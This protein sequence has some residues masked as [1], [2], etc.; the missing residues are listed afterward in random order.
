ML[1][2]R[3]LNAII[4]LGQFRIGLNTKDD[5]DTLTSD[6]SPDCVDVIFSKDNFL[7][8]R[9]GR[10]KLNSSATAA[11]D[12]GNGF[13]DFGVSPGVR[14]LV[15]K[16]G[17]TVYKMDDLDGTFDSL[18]TAQGDCNMHAAQSKTNLI[19]CR[20]DWGKVQYWDGITASAADLNAS[21]PKA[22]YP[23]NWE[24][25]LFLAYP[26]GNPRRFYYEDDTTTTT[27]TWA[28][29]WDIRTTTGGDEFTG[30]ALLRNRL[31]AFF[32]HS[33]HR[34][35]YLGG[36]PLF[37]VNELV[38][39]TGAVPRTIKNIQLPN[40]QEV[41]IFLNWQ[42]KICI[43]D[44]TYVQTIS[45][46]ISSSNGE[47]SFYLDN[48]NT[49]G[50][51]NC[52]ACVDLNRQWYILTAPIGGAT[53]NTHSLVLDYSIMAMFPFKNQTLNASL[54]AEDA[55]GKRYLIGGGYT[56]YAYKLLEGLTDD[57]GAITAFADGGS[58]TVT[59][60]LA[61]HGLNTGDKVVISGTTN[62]NGTFTLNSV[63]Q[64]TFN[65]T[66]TWVSNDGTGFCVAIIAEHYISSKLGGSRI[67]SLKK[68]RKITTYYAPVSNYSLTQYER[69]NFETSWTTRTTIPMYNY[70]DDFLGVDF[71]LGTSTLGSA[72]TKVINAVDLPAVNNLFQ[73]K[74]ASGGVAKRAWRLHKA[75]F[76]EEEV[77]VGAKYENTR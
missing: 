29:Y 63:T 47:S 65:I 45:D 67:S 61:N 68:P 17:S 38:T 9:N 40:G 10:T 25:Y 62:Y 39:T 46:R 18:S 76:L 11:S 35:G 49:G 51:K 5:F 22:R 32:I 55:G 52:H 20:D 58:G 21:A 42:K 41:I 26:D 70:N 7:E 4:D 53:N 75:E 57:I 19:I 1:P 54:Q 8:R 13:A 37:E 64:N 36:D 24:G 33:I 73:F 56:G 48:I 74:L 31:Y 43:F 69:L 2:H 16:F 77:G 66:D 6:E 12:I 71:I 60:T 23:I 50:L 72:K 44:G 27:G 14:K 59:V 34:I 15:A 30:W 3:Q 28:D